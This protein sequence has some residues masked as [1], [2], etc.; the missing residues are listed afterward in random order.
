MA[1]GWMIRGEMH[2]TGPRERAHSILTWYWLAC[3][4]L[5][6]CCDPNGAASGEHLIHQR[7]VAVE[8]AKEGRAGEL[9]GN[10]GRRVEHAIAAG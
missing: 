7:R 10:G 2:T 4:M 5:L 6:V 8:P 3:S 9:V 1:R